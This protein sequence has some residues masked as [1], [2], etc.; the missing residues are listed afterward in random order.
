MWYQY[1]RRYRNKS[2]ISQKAESLHRPLCGGPCS[3]TAVKICATFVVHA[4]KVKV[5]WRR[6]SLVVVFIAQNQVVTSTS[7]HLSPS[8]TW[9]SGD[10]NL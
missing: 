9:A 2:P 8:S 6:A 5:L 3:Y 7:D 4:D 1:P 10:N